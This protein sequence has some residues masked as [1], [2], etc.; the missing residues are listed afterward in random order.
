MFFLLI[1]ISWMTGKNLYEETVDF[2]IILPLRWCHLRRTCRI[3][4]MMI[5]KIIPYQN[6]KD[7]IEALLLSKSKK[8]VFLNMIIHEVMNGHAID[9][10]MSVVFKI[11]L[12]CIKF[13]N[14]ILDVFCS[15][16]WEN[17]CNKLFWFTSTP[18]IA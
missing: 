4:Q 5:A 8:L 14:I 2:Q 9:K 1:G 10:F 16:V 12:I 15:K 13:P 11:I 17:T 6:S 3:Q 7:S 18:Y